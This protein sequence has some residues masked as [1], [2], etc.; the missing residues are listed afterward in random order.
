MED[1]RAP[2]PK[3]QVLQDLVQQIQK[4]A[5]RSLDNQR[6]ALNVEQ[7]KNMDFAS[8]HGVLKRLDRGRFADQDWI[9]HE[10]HLIN[11][12]T[13]TTD[14]LVKSLNRPAYNRQRFS[15]SAAKERTLFMS[16]LFN[17]VESLEGYRLVNQDAELSGKTAAAAAAADENEDLQQ[18]LNNIYKSTKPQLDNQ[19]ASFTL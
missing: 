8:I 15:L 9:S 5:S 3:H 12:L 13:H 6:V 14:L 18:L 4:S 11:D 19:R 7:R 10:E 17:K 16:G 2:L 1:Q